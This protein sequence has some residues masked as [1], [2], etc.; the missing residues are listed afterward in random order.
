MQANERTRKWMIKRIIF[1]QLA[2][3]NRK[4]NKILYGEGKKLRIM[5][6]KRSWIIEEK[7]KRR[8]EEVM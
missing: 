8:Q 3:N 1:F 2:R 7:Y 6:R 5:S 4:G